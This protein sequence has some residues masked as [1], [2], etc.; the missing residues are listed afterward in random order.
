M[1]SDSDVSRV[2]WGLA[3]HGFVV[4]AWMTLRRDET[5]G[6]V[7]EGHSSFTDKSTMTDD[8]ILN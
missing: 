3:H 4:H 8:Y 1:D 7:N 6:V 2:A 5:S